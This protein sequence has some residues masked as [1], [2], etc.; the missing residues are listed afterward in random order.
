MPTEEPLHN[1]TGH[2]NLQP[3]L[4]NNIAKE[5]VQAPTHLDPSRTSA[6]G[7]TSTKL[8]GGHSHLQPNI[9]NNI[10]QKRVQPRSHLDPSC[11][12]AYGGT[13]TK[14][15]GALTYS[16]SFLIIS[17]KNEYSLGRT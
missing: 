15:N 5:R 3:I 11:T 8:Y 12:S 10:A 14:L 16:L 1:C 13:P 7:G 4:F 17:L 2:S 9:F 6:Y